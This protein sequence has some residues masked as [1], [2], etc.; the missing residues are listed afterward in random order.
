MCVHMSI[1]RINAKFVGRSQTEGMKCYN[2]RKPRD[3]I[4]LL[5]DKVRFHQ[6]LRLWLSSVYFLEAA[7]ASMLSCALIHY[8]RSSSN[9]HKYSRVFC[10]KKYSVTFQNILK[11]PSPPFGHFLAQ[12]RN[13]FFQIL[14]PSTLW[15]FLAGGP[16]FCMIADGKS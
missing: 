3:L 16:Y 5:I 6:S 7:K 9:T 2:E 15:A 1:E 11:P 12:T 13:R 10:G 4:S 8:E 14:T